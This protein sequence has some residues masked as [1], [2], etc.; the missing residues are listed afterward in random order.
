MSTPE[1]E[2]HNPVDFSE[3]QAL[4]D[5]ARNDE[6]SETDSG[7]DGGES[8]ADVFGAEDE[9][10]DDGSN[11]ASGESGQSGEEV[12]AD[13]DEDNDDTRTTD[14]AAG[15]DAKP[16]TLKDIAEELGVSAK[17]LYNELLIPMGQGQEPIT[18]GEFKDRVKDLAHIDEVMT[19]TLEREKRFYKEQAAARKEMTELMTVLPREAYTPELLQASQRVARET[20]IRE[21]AALLERIPEWQDGNVMSAEQSKIRETLAEYGYRSYEADTII[22]HRVWAILREFQQLKDTVKNN[23]PDRFRERTGT[24]RG[25][26]KRP[27]SAN[28]LRA[29][30]NKAKRQG[31]SEADKLDAVGALMGNAPRANAGDGTLRGQKR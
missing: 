26:P 18:L 5:G 22:D 10:A 20:A 28:S 9:Q 23:D 14:G 12:T 4:I 3:V 25:A 31:A 24:K 1:N 30:I 27:A 2:I 6:E 7:A 17:D 8:D 13:G 15:E 29:K 16:V 11:E 21:G 19:N